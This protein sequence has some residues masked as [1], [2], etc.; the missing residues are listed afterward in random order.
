MIE[1]KEKLN[2]EAG[3]FFS[4]VLV[5]VL[6][7]IKSATG[8]DVKEGQIHK[9]YSYT[10][11]MKN[12]MGRQGDVKIKITE[13]EPPV[14]Y[15][16]RFQ[17]L[18]GTNSIRY[19]IRDTGNGQIEVTYTEGYDGDTKSQDLNYRIIGAFY[20]RKAKKRTRQML[21]AMETYIRQNREG[22]EEESR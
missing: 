14:L 20:K 2:V 21:H 3:E 18:S 10:K 19:E 11:K 5:S 13:F 17:S 12:K 22:A 4:Q 8:R 16:A 9:G 1:V 7:D 15:G 6:Y